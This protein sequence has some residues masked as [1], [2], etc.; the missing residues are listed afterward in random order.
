MLRKSLSGLRVVDFSQIGAGPT[1]SMFL[2]DLGADVIK[3]E[4]PQGDVGRYLGPPWVFDDESAVFASF[5]RNKRS[6]CLDLK[7]AEGL[8]VALCLIDT[9]DIVVESFRPGVM[10]RLGLGYDSVRKRNPRIVYCSVSAYGQTGEGARQGGVDG[11]IQAASGLMSVLGEEGQPPGKVQAPVVDV[12][13]GHVAAIAVLGQLFERERTGEGGYLDVSMF[14]AAIVLQ[15]PSITGY[16]GD[17][18]LPVRTGSGAPYSAPNEAFEARDGWIM[19]AAYQ[20]GRWERLCSVLD[21]PALPGDPRFATSSARVH[22]RAAM[23][24][25]LAPAFR[26]RDCAHW[27]E[28]LEANDILCSKVCDYGDLLDNTKLRHLNLLAEIAD[29]R[30]RTY[31]MPGFPVN[32]QESQALAH[33]APPRCG[34]HSVEILAGMGYSSED[35]AALASAGVVA[36]SA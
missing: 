14:A 27:V 35:I 29:D 8:A 5:N 28:V 16:L 22:N 1:C 20:G 33:T 26:R 15:Q 21:M 11:I 32:C 36:V 31:R 13:T 23:R 2:G 18:T 24:A 12:V 34:Q 19:V 7:T 10:D 6:L 3:V 25:M 4:S 30:G 17:G 9:A